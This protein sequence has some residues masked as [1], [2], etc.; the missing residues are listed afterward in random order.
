MGIFHS[1]YSG[2]VFA[3]CPDL[4][5]WR[6][7]TGYAWL[8]ISPKPF[9]VSFVACYFSVSSSRF[10]WQES[11]HTLWLPSA[12]YCFCICS[13]HVGDNFYNLPHIG[14]SGFDFG[15]ETCPQIHFD[16]SMARHLIINT[17]TS[18]CGILL[19]VVVIQ[20][21]CIVKHQK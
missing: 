20:R 11:L 19:I 8:L 6:L 21:N 17:T 14:L 16:G 18:I 5:Q 15:I 13:K 2:T 1:S 12:C 7:P 4:V 9:I 10:E 3:T